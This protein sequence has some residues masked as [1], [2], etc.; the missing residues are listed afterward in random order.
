MET[1]TS[2]RGQGLASKGVYVLSTQQF[3]VAVV[4]RPGCSKQDVCVCVD[5]WVRACVRECMRAGEC[6]DS[7]MIHN[8]V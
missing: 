2:H 5:G 8:C 3:Q 7:L 1:K 6:V 4:H